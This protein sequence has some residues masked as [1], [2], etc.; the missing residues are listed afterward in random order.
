M[1]VV[2]VWL[3]VMERRDEFREK[4]E[5]IQQESWNRYEQEKASREAQREARLKAEEERESRQ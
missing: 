3:Q 5:S 4:R 2:S 1:Y